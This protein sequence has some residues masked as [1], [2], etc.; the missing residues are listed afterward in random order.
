[1]KAIE[2]RDLSFSYHLGGK[3]MSVLRGISLSIE[4]GEFVA[5]QGRSGS[6][7]STLL[8]ILGLLLRPSAGQLLINGM[9]T[10]EM[11]EAELAAWRNQHL[12]FVFQQF[13]LLPGT[14]IVDNILLPRFYSGA[15]PPVSDEDRRKAR[16][17][18]SRFDLTD[19]LFKFPN[20]L[21][22]G[23]QQRV[24]MARALMNGGD[25]I[26]ADE[27]TGSLDYAN[28]EQAMGLLKELNKMGRT[29]V[30][31]T[32]DPE[33]SR[34]CPRVIEIRDGRVEAREGT[35]KIFAATQPKSAPSRPKP[36]SAALLGLLERTTPLAVRSVVRAKSRS[37]LAMLGIVVAVGAILATITVG[38]F[39]RAK[40]L[41]S[42]EALGVNRLVLHGYPNRR[43]AASETAH[44]LFEQFDWNKD[45]VPLLRNFPEISLAS[46]EIGSVGTGSLLGYKLEH[47]QNLGI[48]PD[49]FAIGRQRVLGGRNITPY[50]LR[51]RSAVCVVGDTIQ[52]NVPDGTEVIGN[53]IQVSG[54]EGETFACRI[55]GIVQTITRSPGSAGNSVYVFLPYTFL[56]IVEPSSRLNEL[57]LQLIP[58]R[59]VD[60]AAR[61]IKN[62]FH[63]R[64]SKSGFFRPDGEDVL[65][66]QMKRFLGLFAILL[67]GVAFI[68]LAVGG[69]GVS[70]MMLVSV[71]DRF[72]EFGVRKAFGA[73]DLDIRA[74]VLTEAV[75]IC[76]TAGLLGLVAGFVV[77]E[78]A[79]FAASRFVTSVQF[80]WIIEPWAAAVAGA[81][82]FAV[83]LASG[84]MPA[85]KAERLQIIE[86]LRTE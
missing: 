17:L 10:S 44:N 36:R 67:A 55:V 74:Q 7:K 80:E 63:Q 24:A 6:G 84:L 78:F 9:D 48:G 79:I 51:E 62:Y 20:Q 38:K 52:K 81:S 12:G 42:Y 29:I 75:L 85:L 56:Q 76:G 37:A 1:L 33:V 66:A 71:Q 13:Q 59:D 23:Q 31:V 86:V 47:V 77:Y 19:H 45:L 25:I 22:G 54:S 58:G 30:L 46:P 68:S 27:P 41:A 72:R 53:I 14:N 3:E 28:A 60:V 2:A 69:I 5:I 32:H 39:T 11:D 21:S 4:P 18:A 34:W 73:S 82:I 43:M 83:G 35:S 61:G 15:Q 57:I 16:E 50:D 26:L 40:I 65:V 64:Y 70:N 49:Y 8:Y